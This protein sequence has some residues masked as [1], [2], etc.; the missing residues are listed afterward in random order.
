MISK[1]RLPRAKLEQKILGKALQIALD[2][3]HERARLDAVE[4]GQGLVEQ[5]LVAAKEEDRLRDSLGRY[6]GCCLA[7]LVDGNLPLSL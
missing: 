1:N 5:H 4:S 7:L 2:R 3:L 6:E